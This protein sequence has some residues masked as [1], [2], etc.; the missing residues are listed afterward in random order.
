MKRS[1]IDWSVLRSPLILLVATLLLGGALIAGGYYFQQRTFREYTQQQRRFQAMSHK[2]L[3][4]DE[5]ERLIRT[6][7]PEFQDLESQ[8]ILGQEQRLGWTETVRKVSAELRLPSVRYEIEP[9]KPYRPA[10]PV[11]PGS[12]RVYGSRMRLLVG[13]LH[14]DDLFRLFGGLRKQA[15]GLFTVSRCSLTR[16][17]ATIQANLKQANLNADCELIWLTLRHPSAAELR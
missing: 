16:A 8:G 7:L 5:E 2:Y 9:Q 11:P 12:F 1:D 10:Y 3:A 4:V 13:L 17:G 14:E 15:E 6:Y